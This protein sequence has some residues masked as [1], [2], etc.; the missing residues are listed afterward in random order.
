MIC[1]NGPN[2]FKIKKNKEGKKKQYVSHPKRSQCTKNCTARTPTDACNKIRMFASKIIL[3]HPGKVPNA[4]KVD[5]CNRV[6]TLFIW[7]SYTK[8]TKNYV[9]TSISIFHLKIFVR[10]IIG[11][12][13]QFS[14]FLKFRQA[15]AFF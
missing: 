15:A 1:F 12:S 4:A 3:Q 5:K 10:R 13:V 7:I 2:L 9:Y 11:T 6:T 14:R 8:T